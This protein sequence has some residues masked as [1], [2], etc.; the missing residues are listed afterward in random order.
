MNTLRK[1]KKKG[2]TLVEIIVVL[3]II[4]ILM[5]ALTPVILGWI[6]EARNT[7]MIA[8]G[9]TGLTAAQALITDNVG[10][11]VITAG[12][13][14]GLA[15]V[16]TFT[17]TTFGDL[18]ADVRGVTGTPAGSVNGFTNVTFVIENSGQTIRIATLD[19]TTGGRTVQ[20]RQPGAAAGTW[21]IP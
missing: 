15:T 21:N 8:E 2:F 18:T 6:N 3:V 1:T 4:A 17:G 10:R 7:A 16:Q 11:G 9:R 14:L 5:A 13:T 20:W 19:Y 12:G